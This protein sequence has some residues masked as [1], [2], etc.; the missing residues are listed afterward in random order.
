[1]ALTLS[2]D[3]NIDDVIHIDSSGFV[4]IGTGTPGYVFDLWGGQARFERSGHSLYFNPNYGTLNTYSAIVSTLDLS[5]RNGSD[6]PV[7]YFDN[8]NVRVGIGVTDPDSPLEVNSNAINLNNANFTN[9]NSQSYGFK[10]LGGGNTAT[11]YI[12]DFRAYGNQTAFKID[13]DANIIHTGSSPEYHFATTNAS[14]YNWRFAA[15]ETA[16][17]GFEISSGTQS[18]ATNAATDT[19]TPRLIVKAN[20]TILF[21]KVSSGSANEGVEIDNHQLVA[22][23]DSAHPLLVKRLTDFGDIAQF[24]KDTAPTI[25]LGAAAGPVGYIV[26]NDATSDNVAALKGASRAILPSTNTGAD[27]DGTMDLGGNSAKFRDLYLGGG[28]QFESGGGSGTATN[29]KLSGYEEGTWTP[30][31]EGE[32][33]A[34]TTSYAYRVGWYR[35]VGSIVVVHCN[36]QF[37]TNGTGRMLIKGLPYV[38]NEESVG[39][40]QANKCGSWP[41]GVGQYTSIIQGGESYIHMR[42]TY[43]NGNTGPHYFQ[44]QNVDYMR[45]TITYKT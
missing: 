44:M 5:F 35:K 23:K 19:Y 45:I 11:R 14:H 18:A 17:A 21:N 2:G 37:T 25:R 24:Y 1:M 22:S 26:L 16:D 31:A 34:G 3:K 4:G 40:W 15:Q 38:C 33:T 42:G 10:S 7:V 27:K 30:T 13:G 36:L 28:I 39:S 43:N 29:L 6:L 8:T 41:A 32:T 12:A 9:S 20:G